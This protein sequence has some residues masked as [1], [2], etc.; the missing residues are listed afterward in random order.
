MNPSLSRVWNSPT[1]TTWGSMAV[2]LAGVLLMLPLVLRQFPPAE[3][4]VWQLFASLFTLV[5]LLD[6]GVTPTAAR[7]LAYARGG[8][9]LDD[10]AAMRHRKPTSDLATDVAQEHNTLARV[11]GA[12]RWLYPRLALL[13][14]VLFAV[15]GTLGLL[16]PI[17]QC[18]APQRMWLAWGV[19]LLGSYV[20]FVGNAYAATLQGLNHIAP[21]RR[22]EVASG[23]G[24]IVCSLTALL[25]GADLLVLILVY[26]SWTLFNTWR[27]RRLLLALAPQLRQQT[28]QFD[29]GVTGQMWP[30][31]WRSGL[32]VLFGQGIVQASGLA[33]GQFAAAADVA[34]YLLALRVVTTLSQFSQAPFYSKLP[35]L[36]TLHAQGAR[37]QQL[38]LAQAGMRLAQWVLVAGALAVG[39][40]LPWL[41]QAIGSQTHFVSAQ[42]WALMA[43]AFFVERFGAMHLQLYSLTNHIVW[44]IANGVTGLLMVA[45]AALLYPVMQ[46][47][48]LPL[49]MLLAYAGFY[50]SYA[51]WHSSRAF[52]FSVLRFEWRAGAPAGMVLVA[53]LLASVVGNQWLVNRT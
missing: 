2:R 10:M 14:V 39:F 36:A 11:Y 12:L 25:N 31:V 35:Q 32:G 44:H 38:V 51:A 21:L 5:L 42:V 30:Q 41:L 34:S 53:G 1:L 29:P 3:V 28:S 20:A 18:V 7:M 6:F 8:A 45:L 16:K 17:A 13:A 26:Q 24:Q 33:Y 4:A 48:A 40:G 23:L 46:L 52:N 47:S 49:A 22:W 9:T 27:N 43:I 50:A 15:V 37:E 19:V